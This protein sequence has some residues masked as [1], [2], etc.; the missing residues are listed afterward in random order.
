MIELYKITHQIAPPI[1]NSLFVFHDNMHNIRNHHILSK[2]IRKTVRYDLETILYRSP[3][4]WANLPQE[5]KLQ[6]SISAFKRK[7]RQWNSEIC[8]CRLSKFYKP[9]IGFIYIKKIKKSLILF[10]KNS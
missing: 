4:L 1:M 5:Y 10:S 9:N 3:F 7:I 8:V 6:K 2:D